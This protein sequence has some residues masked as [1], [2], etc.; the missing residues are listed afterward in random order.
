MEGTRRDINIRKAFAWMALNQMD[1]IWKSE[2]LDA[3]TLTTVKAI[4]QYGSATWVSIKV[5]GVKIGWLIHTCA[6]ESL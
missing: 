5:G 1:K 6:G 3:L 4:L 2:P